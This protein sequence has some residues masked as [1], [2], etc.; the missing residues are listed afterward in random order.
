MQKTDCLPGLR[1]HVVPKQMK[2]GGVHYSRRGKPD[3]G[4]VRGTASYGPWVMV[5]MD[6]NKSATM[7]D[8]ARLTPLDEKGTP[9]AQAKD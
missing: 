8:A 2:H 4:T 3:T 5:Q 7:Y 9:D 1:V 6:G